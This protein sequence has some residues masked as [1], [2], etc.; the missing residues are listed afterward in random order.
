MVKGTLRALVL[1]MVAVLA[2]DAPA[3]AQATAQIN[4]TVTDASGGVLPGT[5]VT[6][7]Q[8]DT[9]FRRSAVTDASG[10]YTLPNLPVGPYRLEVNLSGFR[11]YVQTGIVLQV[12]A[13][14]VINVR[15]ELGELAE[16]IT[17]Q[18]AAPLVETRTTSIGQVIENERIVALPLNGRNPVELIVLAGAA[19]SQATTS[20]GTFVGSQGSRTVSVAG[21]HAGSTAYMLDGAMHNNPY[22][23]LNLPLPFPDALQEFRVETSAL[24]AQAG[25]HS[26]ASVTSVTRSGTNALHGTLFE[27][28]RDRR[29]NAT[30]PFAAVG[31][32]GERQDDGLN[33][34]QFGGTIGGPLLRDR[35]FFFA[36]VQGTRVKQV[37]SSDIAFVPTAAMLAGDFSAVA[38]PA[39]NAG[40]QVTLRGPF[41]NNRIDPTR[42][43]RA[44]LAIAAKLPTS[45]DPCGR[46]VYSTPN[47]SDEQQYVGKIDLQLTQ[48]HSMFGR[49]LATK[50][51]NPVAFGNG[52][53]NILTSTQNSQNNLAQSV[54]YGDTLILSSSTVNALRFAFNRTAIFRTLADTFSA[55]SVGINTHSYLP[56]QIILGVQNAFS[57]GG[58]AAG[59]TFDTNTYN[60]S[61]DLT[62]VRGDHQ[63]TFGA[64]IAWWDSFSSANIRSPGNFE[65]DGQV[66]GLP[67][68]DFLT[69]N[70]SS[71]RQTAPNVLD[72][73][74]WYGGVYAQD[75]WRMS[76]RVTLNYGVRWEPFIPQ[77][78]ENIFVFDQE[79]YLQ[80][81]KSTVFR[82][83]PAGFMYRGD[84]GFEGDSGM[85]ARWLKFSPR[86][87]LAWDPTGEG[88]MSVR[89]SYG[90]ANDFVVGRYLINTSLAAPWSS[91]VIL[92]VPAGGFQDPFRGVPGGN[93]FPI[94]TPLRADAPFPVGGQYLA[95]QPDLENTRVQSWNLSVQRQVGNAWAGSVTYMG[96]H[97]SHLW[98]PRSINYGVYIPGGPCTLADGRTYNP[99]STPR[100]TN[101]RRVLSVQNWPE[102]QLF[103]NL[104]LHDDN[105]YQ[106]YHGLMLTFQRRGA[107]VTFN[108]N[109]TL[110]RCT[111]TPTAAGAVPNAGQGY[112]DPLNIAHDEGNC[113]LNRTHLL[114]L[115]AGYETP[116]LS[117]SAWRALL[118]GWRISGIFRASSGNWLNITVTGDPARTGF[119]AQRPNRVL[120]DPYGD[121]SANTFLNPAAFAQPALGT[122]G[123]LPRNAVEGPRHWTL[124]ASL[125]RAFRFN[126]AQRLEVRVE[127]FNLLNRTQLGNP[128]TNLNSPTFG[129]ILS[130]GDPR[131]M[132][133]AVKYAF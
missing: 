20:T 4:G 123:D 21:G 112:V 14:P 81:V 38:S 118:S 64:N 124:D 17:V 80:G 62:L 30:D 115:T 6:A 60:V 90:L 70:L 98:N 69:G 99:C 93:P 28:L 31:A 37:P 42:L 55:P 76:Q 23:N 36:G 8:T 11:P 18:G 65:F 51:H 35:M 57:I 41:V 130:A 1:T 113:D 132:Q 53:D 78:I 122:F 49:Y 33:R 7:I 121:K 116:E 106:T 3:F 109:Y 29:F 101:A 24:A 85:K 48:N 73:S 12:N 22:D 50:F 119:G 79:K 103:A 27:F 96:N 117:N 45:T 13:N 108:G 88:L 87:G 75:S 26:G 82:N 58:G 39:C 5:D 131:I 129:R 54:V 86:V 9:G 110:S 67:L 2:V 94:P 84:P 128:V 72:M 46:I 47:P 125:V 16:T 40:R 92:P 97:S 133:F 107:Q 71:F 15:L 89:M 126:A 114:N 59:A 34:N 105:G 25:V 68:A 127:A 102:G 95:P 111:G 43:D 44:A 83:A 63:W 10:S 120:D 104:D 100:N 91:E 19:V 77:R 52:S 61:N 66:T 74:Q 32:D 56:N